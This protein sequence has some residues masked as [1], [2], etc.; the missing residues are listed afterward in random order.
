M[1][2]FVNK[3]CK[4]LEIIV[5]FTGLNGKI[6]QIEWGSCTK[7][8]REIEQWACTRLSRGILLEIIVIFTGLNGKIEWGEWG[9]CTR[10]NREIEWFLQKSEQGACMR[11]TKAASDR[12]LSVCL[13]KNV[14]N[15]W[16]DIFGVKASCEKIRNRIVCC[17]KE[18]RSE[19]PTAECF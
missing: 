8:N 11:L 3:L 17:Q 14:G 9:S 13:C 16:F 1:S 12:K 2:I 15:T 4:R 10:L 7:L 6:E 19:N 18:K 5:I